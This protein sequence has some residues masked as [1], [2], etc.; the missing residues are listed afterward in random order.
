MFKKLFFFFFLRFTDTVCSR[1]N[2][3]TQ[4]LAQN[5]LWGL[6]S[7]LSGH[8]DSSEGCFVKAVNSEFYGQMNKSTANAHQTTGTKTVIPPVAAE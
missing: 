5:P 8:Q 3:L 1:I 6:Y 4:K 7:A 2:R